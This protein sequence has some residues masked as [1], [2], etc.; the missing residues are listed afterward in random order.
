MKITAPKVVTKRH[1]FGRPKQNA[2]AKT[3]HQIEPRKT[4]IE[5]PAD[6]DTHELDQVSESSEILE[7]ILHSKKSTINESVQED[8]KI[9]ETEHEEVKQQEEIKQIEVAHE[10]IVHTETVRSETVKKRISFKSIT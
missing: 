5:V 7:D 2:Q 9:E 1:R 4:S 10:S 6:I 8:I 3:P